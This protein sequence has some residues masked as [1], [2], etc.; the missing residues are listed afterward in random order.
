MTWFTVTETMYHKD[1]GKQ[2]P[3]LSP[4]MPYHRV[5]N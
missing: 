5:C 4:F 3:D 1:H 2:F